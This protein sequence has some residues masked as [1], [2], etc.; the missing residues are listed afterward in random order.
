[1]ICVD[2]IFN[3]LVGFFWI[4]F[5]L[6]KGLF[7][8]GYKFLNYVYFYDIL[9][10]EWCIFIDNLV[11]YSKYV[12]FE[13]YWI[14]CNDICDFVINICVFCVCDFVFWDYRKLI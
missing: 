9:L 13:W 12:L 6:K 10:I 4:L 5:F 8:L 14:F 1:M 7:I 2:V 11:W 3:K